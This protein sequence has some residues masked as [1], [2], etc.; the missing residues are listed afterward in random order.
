M[1]CRPCICTATALSKTQPIVNVHSLK[2][3]TAQQP[4]QIWRFPHSILPLCPIQ[5]HPMPLL[6][7]RN[8]ADRTPCLRLPTLL[9]A[10]VHQAGGA[11]AL[12][13]SRPCTCQPLGPM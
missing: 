7:W 12:A 10:Q 11:T 2:A 3:L 5:P 9:Q 13:L 4:T 6:C 8:V 1:R